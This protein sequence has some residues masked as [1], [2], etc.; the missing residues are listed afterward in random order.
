MLVLDCAKIQKCISIKR[1]SAYLKAEI[2]VE[3]LVTFENSIFYFGREL[4]KVTTSMQTVV[5]K[6]DRQVDLNVLDFL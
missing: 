3:R 6:I 2:D 5:I 4:P 1:K